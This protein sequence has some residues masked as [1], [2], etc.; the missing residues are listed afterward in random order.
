[1]SGKHAKYTGGLALAALLVLLLPGCRARSSRSGASST[2]TEGVRDSVAHHA[3]PAPR[4]AVPGCWDYADLLRKVD[5]CGAV[6]VL[7]PDTLSSAALDSLARDWDGALMRDGWVRGEDPFSVLFYGA[8]CD[9]NVPRV[10][11]SALA[12]ETDRK[13]KRYPSDVRDVPSLVSKARTYAHAKRLMDSVFTIDT[14][15]DLPM[16]Y[17]DGYSLGKK[18]DNQIN[19]PKMD[20][21]HLDSHVLISYI[22]QGDTDSAGLRRAFA[23]CDGIIDMI[24]RDVQD[25]AERCS[26]VYTPSEALRVKAE[27]RKPFFI[28]IENGHGLGGRLSS[29]EHYA[30][31]GVVYITLSHT[32]DNLLCHT[33]SSNSADTTAGLTPFGRQVVEEMNRLGVMVDCS[34][35]SSGTLRDCLALS[36]APVICS[37]SGAMAL[38][39]HDRNLTDSQMRAVAAGGGVV[40]V[41]IVD[42]FMDR[43]PSRVGIDHFMDHLLHTIEVAGIDHTGI[44]CDFDGGG[45][46]WGLNGDNDMINITVR[47]LEKG[48]S[49]EDIA[50]VWGGNFLRVL[51]TV[52]SLAP[53]F[54]FKDR[55]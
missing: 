40:Q 2:G 34:H 42:T 43:D 3:E 12:A 48:F 19:L 37:H 17:S 44:A 14:H 1:M 53:D 10:G 46:G 45:G 26:V 32:R 38:Y 36:K 51:S 20:A 5:S 33:S 13:L 55:M 22:R 29:V 50:K 25:N 16:S 27:G 11:T 21:G 23:K 39:R 41:Y 31:R 18:G 24:Y 47:L 35:T 4:I 52:Q 28:G 9:Y 8:V 54:P 7:V 49:D 15:G 30:R 6:A